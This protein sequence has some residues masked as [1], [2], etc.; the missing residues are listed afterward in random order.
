M[1]T[2][3]EAAAEIEMSAVLQGDNSRRIPGAQVSETSRSSPGPVNPGDGARRKG[4]KKIRRREAA[5]KEI[6]LKN[7][8]KKIQREEKWKQE[9]QKPRDK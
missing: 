9:G 7:E 5:R 4:E 6:E 3:Y 1:L 8:F 2:G